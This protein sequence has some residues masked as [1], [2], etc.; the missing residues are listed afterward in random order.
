MGI[1]HKFVSL[2]ADDADSTLVRPSNWNDDHSIDGGTSFP[3]SP[4]EKDLYY[5]TDL[6]KWYIYSGTAWVE[7]TAVYT[8]AEA[9]AAAKT[10]KLD[11]F[12]AP[13][14]N[15]D[16]NASASAHGLLPKLSNVVTEFLNGQGGWT[17]PA[18]GG[19]ALTSNITAFTRALDGASG[20]VAY[21][22]VGFQPTCLI[23]IMAIQDDDMMAIGFA[24]DD[25]DDRSILD[26][27]AGVAGKYEMSAYFMRCQEGAAAGQGCIVKSYDADGFTLTWTLFG[28]PSAK[29]LQVYILCLK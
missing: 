27:Y 1:K 18:G 25:T 15:T 22:G 16:L 10:I 9:I 24:D 20:D 4:A 21:T 28:T 3:G 26:G 11:D 8:D 23:G 17:T 5:R 14:D 13:D 6:H 2:K 7:L 29:T 19:S 12:A